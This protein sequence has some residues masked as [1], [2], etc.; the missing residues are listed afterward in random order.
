MYLENFK[1][2][3]KSCSVVFEILDVRDP[4]STRSISVEKQILEINPNIK[5]V[6]VLNKI[7]L[8]PKRSVENWLKYFR[9]DVPTIAFKS[10]IPNLPAKKKREFLYLKKSPWVMKQFQIF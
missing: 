9:K 2:M 3:I 8:V 6:L 5:L 10:T 4:L 1:E 7:D